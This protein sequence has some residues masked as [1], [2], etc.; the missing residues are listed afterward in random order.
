MC[1]NLIEPDTLQVAI[2]RMRFSCWKTKAINA[3]S[4]YVIFFFSQ[5]Q[6]LGERSSMSCYSTF[7]LLFLTRGD[8]EEANLDKCWE[9]PCKYPH[10]ATA[11]RLVLTGLT[12]LTSRHKT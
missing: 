3:H 8:L 1:I 5:Q 4:E 6:W 12:L 2:R 11:L 10:N 9:E 7:L